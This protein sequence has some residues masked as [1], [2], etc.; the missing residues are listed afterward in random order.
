MIP[1]KIHYCWFGGKELPQLAQKC[2]ASWEKYCPDWEI[3]RWDESN[4]D[5]SRYPFAEYCLKNKKWAFLS[6]IVRLVVIYEQG[7]VYLD[8]DVEL[9]RSLNSLCI[10]DAYYGFELAEQINTGHG[11]GAV[12]GHETVKALLDTYLQLRPDEKGDYPLI[13]CPQLNTE[14][15]VKMGLVLNGK[16]Q[17]IAGAEIYPIAY[18]NPYEYTTGRM[19]KTSHTYSIHWFNQSWISPWRKIRFKLTKPFHY[20]FGVDCFRWLKK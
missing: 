20:L 16:H 4:F 1:K 8:T 15:L 2:I 9:V 19:K 18:F 6:D 13:A 12:A 17:Q 7:G 11:F 14:P 5:F 3:L 10:H